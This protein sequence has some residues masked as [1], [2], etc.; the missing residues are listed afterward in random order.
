M[1][2][3]TIYKDHYEVYIKGV[4]E[5]ILISHEWGER[6]KF[7]LQST[8]CPP[9]VQ[10]NNGLYNRFE[11]SKIVPASQKLNIVEQM[12]VDLSPELREKVRMKARER[13]KANMPLTEWVVRNM[14]EAL[15]K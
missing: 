15:T 6:L 7:S 1:S 14:I 12:I 8:D 2:Q 9:F 10:I 5:P 3:I 4:E 11:I 13:E